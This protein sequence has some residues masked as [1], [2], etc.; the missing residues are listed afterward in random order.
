MILQVRFQSDST[1]ITGYRLRLLLLV[2]T[3]PPPYCAVAFP[4]TR[5]TS[6][7][8]ACK[9][10]PNASFRVEPNVRG[11]FHTHSFKPKIRTVPTSTNKLAQLTTANMAR[12]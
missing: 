11:R 3:I 5:L 8:L 7:L 10:V 1:W 9:A 6:T 12:V 2:E 4:C